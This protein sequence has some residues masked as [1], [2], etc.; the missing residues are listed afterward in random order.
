MRPQLERVVLA[1]LLGALVLAGAA[2]AQ[3]LSQEERISALETRL[4]GIEAAQE[5]V[6]GQVNQMRL[7]VD[8]QLEPLRVRLA[9]YGEDVRGMESRLVAVEE[10]LA[11]INDRLTDIADSLAAGGTG[12]AARPV[13]AGQPM[14]PPQRP[15][16]VPAPSVATP[17]EA[18]AAA[19][20]AVARSEAE[21]LYSTA[22]TDYLAANYA[23]AVSGFEEYLRLF[24]DA[25][26]A[27]NAQYWVGESHFSRQQYQVAR[28]AFQELVRR[29]PDAET[30]PDAKFKA[31]RCLVE[32]GD[33][34]RAIEELVRL[35]REHPDAETL[36][37]ACLQIEQLGGQKP[38]GCP[39]E[40]P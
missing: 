9:D 11:L 32:I 8:N 20:P 37:I 12:A 15:A 24:P 28:T 13:S 33:G 39:G 4:A 2:P 5:S 17:A 14:P 36:P 21:S 19:P 7:D 1:T 35:V 30:V 26:L 29:W 27:D 6:L 40:L 31:A 10:Q 16:G 3:R 25:D 18:G 34:A 38:L 23:L 22:Y